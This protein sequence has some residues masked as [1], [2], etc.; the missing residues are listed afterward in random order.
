ME[1][2]AFK[3]TMKLRWHELPVRGEYGTICGIK[4]GFAECGNEYF[5]LQQWWEDAQTGSG[6]WRDIEQD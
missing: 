3:P 6:E 4:M 5:I 2:E 1:P